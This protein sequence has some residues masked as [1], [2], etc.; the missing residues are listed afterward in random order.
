MKVLPMGQ[1]CPGSGKEG[2]GRDEE[3][4]KIR[5]LSDYSADRAHLV[6]QP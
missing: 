4:A 3:K 5:H 1:N 2:N 6:L